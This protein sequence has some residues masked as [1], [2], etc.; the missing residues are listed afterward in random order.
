QSIAMRAYEH[1]PLEDVQRWG[2]IRAGKSLFDSILVFENFHLNSM[3]RHQGGP[4]VSREFHI[5]EQTNYPLVL[6]AYAGIELCLKIGFDGDRLNDATA[7]R[8]L[9]HLQTLLQAIPK[10]PQQLLRDLP[11]L[12]TA[13]THELLLE[14]NR[15]E[16]DYPKDS[17]V[18]QL[19]EAQVERTPEA[20]AVIFEDRHVTYEE[21]N[22]RSNRV[23]HYL[24]EVGVGPGILVGLCV[25]PSLER[26]IGLLGILKAGGAY[27]PIDPAYPA[28]RLGFMLNDANAPVVL[29]QRAVVPR[30]P[31]L[32]AKVICLD[33]SEWEVIEG[34]TINPQRTG[35]THDL[36]YV[37]YTSGSTGNPKGVMISHRSLVNIMSW[38][39]SAFPADEHDCVLHHISLSFDPSVLEILTP[40]LVGGRLVVAL[41][42]GHRD[43]GYLVETIIRDEVTILH[44]VPSMLRM[45]LEIPDFKHC[46]S[47]RHVFCGGEVL[48]KDIAERFF[49]VLDAELHYV[50]GPTEA[51]ITSLSY[52]VPRNFCDEILPIGRPVANTQAY[53]LDGHR[54]PVPIG[55]PGELYLGG[56]QVGR[57]YHNCPDLTEE[58]FIADPFKSASGAQLYKTGDLVR[59]LPGGMIQFLG[60]VDR[61]VKIRGHR[62][63]LGEIETVIRSHPNVEES[64]VVVRE[65]APGDNKLVAYVRPKSSCP[66]LPTAL[67][68]ALKERLPA[69]MLPSA[70]I[71]LDAFPVTPNG[72]LDVEALRSAEISSSGSEERGLRPRTPVEAALSGFWCEALKLKQIS[73]QDNFF[74]MGGHSLMIV[75]LINRI[76]QAFNVSLGVP[77]LFH[78]PTVEKLA[79]VIADH[80]PGETHGSRAIQFQEG[81]G[82]RPLFFAY[83][84]LNESR[85][86]RLIDEK[87]PV[88]GIDV[89]WLDALANNAKSAFPTVEQLIAPYLAVLSSC[90][91]FSPCLLAGHSFGG[92]L[93]FELAH[94]FQA[95]GGHVDLVI[96]FDSWARRPTVREAAWQQLR[97]N[98]KRDPLSTHGP[99]SFGSRLKCSRLVAQ[100]MLTQEAKAAYR[101][102]VER[103]SGSSK[104]LDEQSQPTDHF[105]RKIYQ[106]YYPR[107]LN[108]RGILLRS[109]PPDESYFRAFDDTLGWRNLFAKGLKIVPVLGDHF[110]AINQPNETLIQALAHEMDESVR[111]R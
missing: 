95:Q 9:G 66:E 34:N 106:S 28:A 60:R 73:V 111:L 8:M 55:V 20:V 100:W 89:P 47:L 62:I 11:L 75:Q 108:A 52:S 26:I 15:T 54:R 16:A 76:N 31:P 3:L 82:E 35:S 88:L 71:L 29:T 59:R 46:G 21:L 49:E 81:K 72:K 22:S 99:Q 40:L 79:K 87:Y 61:Q 86:A 48:P 63:E 4:W 53:V 43:A 69:H 10:N 27:V 41:P 90:G 39:Q 96:L 30:L 97:K 1:T 67:R 84:G 44:V 104:I 102:L 103:Q 36:A 13:E 33:S 57:G 70:F 74:E 56:V 6:A 101:A 19:F 77:D 58:R 25:D 42:N 18:H 14:W 17:Y 64:V 78:N 7:G 50:Y 107:A 5:F 38:M 68:I 105:Y 93:A 92:V 24:R 2:D 94:Q 109:D 83:A 110:A 37:I 23:A 85:L 91:R 65:D 12:T 45:L 80:P 32:G 51:T 98:W